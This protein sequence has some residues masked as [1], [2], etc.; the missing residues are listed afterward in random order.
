MV[1][2]QSILFAFLLLINWSCETPEYADMILINGNIAAIDS[3]NQGA[4]AIAIKDGRFL[5]IGT[6]EEIKALKNDK[7]QVIDLDGKF[8]MAGFI[9]GHGHFSGMGK[10]LMNINL[11]ESKNWEQI[12]NAVAEKAKTSKPGEWIYGRGWHQEKWD[13]SPAR[14]FGGYPYH[15]QLSEVTPDNPVILVHASGHSIF[16]NKKA[17]ETVGISKETPNPD[18][19]NIVRDPKGEAIGVF[20][21]TAAGIVGSAYYDYIKSLPKEVVYNNWLKGIQ[22]AEKE[23][24]SKGIT[25]FQ[26][27]GSSFEEIENYKKLAENGELDLRLW[28]MIRHSYKKMKGNLDGF[29]LKNIGNHFLTVNA[30]K[31]EVDGALGSYGAWL[32]QPYDDKPNF[33]GQNTTTISEVKNIASLAY[34][35]DLQLCVHA[36]GD[37]ANREVLNIFEENFKSNPNKKDLRWRIEHAQHLDSADIPRFKELGVIASMQGIHCTS[38]SPFVVKR[39]GEQRARVG[40]YPWRTLLDNGVIIAN[41]TDAPVEDVDP[42]EC[43]YASVTRKRTDT[44]LEFF[45]EQRMTRQEAL[46]SYTLGNAYAAFEENDKGSISVGKLADIVVLSK[47]L[48]HCSDDEILETEVLYTIVG[49]DVK[50]EKK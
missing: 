27:A 35:H 23:C 7:T 44:G 38:D 8:A 21:E 28:V 48:L 42:I 11:M 47:D 39:L 26:D 43:F 24:L 14:Q 50:Y 10:S 32:L 41:G 5:K 46:Y 34:Q 15:D 19:G 1:K 30:I 17:M 6:N 37:R 33:I 29:P 40:A 4:S 20:E 9:E 18:G 45:P 16:A 31:S 36:I 3:L 49:G 22:L 13:K 12:V 25:S 2:I